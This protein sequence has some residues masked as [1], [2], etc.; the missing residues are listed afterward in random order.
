MDGL[1]KGQFRLLHHTWHLHLLHKSYILLPNVNG[2]GKTVESD[3]WFGEGEAE[4]GKGKLPYDTYVI[5]ELECEANQ[6]YILIPP[7]EVVVERNNQVI[8][9]GTLTN[10]KTPEEPEEPEE[11]E[12]PEEPEKPEIPEK[13]EMP[14]EQ[15]KPTPVPN[16]FRTVKTGDSNGLIVLIISLILSCVTVLKCVRMTRRK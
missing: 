14:E 16:V 1:Q 13:P 3:I 7:F 6:D 4:T 2:E 9:L 12:I 15:E 11:P 8:H 10:E 5:E